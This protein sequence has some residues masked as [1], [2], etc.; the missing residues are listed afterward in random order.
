M[1]RPRSSTDRHPIQKSA[2]I[3]KQPFEENRLETTPAENS[4]IPVMRIK[5]KGG[6]PKGNR[7]A[8]KNGR[9]A[10]ENIALRRRCRAFIRHCNAVV[11][12][13]N[14]QIRDARLSWPSP[15][16]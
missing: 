11:R 15:N 12:S 9:F 4:A 1:R 7:N 16:N 6:A 5:N 8:F 14:R 13:V 2:K 10:A 3:A